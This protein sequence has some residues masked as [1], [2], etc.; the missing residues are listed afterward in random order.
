MYDSVGAHCADAN[1]YNDVIMGAIASKITSFM[2]VYSIVNSDADQRK[3]QSSVSLNFVWGVHR[4]TGEFPA[5][6]ASYAENVSIWWRH[7]DISAA[8]K[9]YIDGWL[10]ERR[11]S[12]ANSVVF[13]LFADC[14]NLWSGLQLIL[15][16]FLYKERR[17]K[18]K[19][20]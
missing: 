17:C 3:Y 4:E 20:I 2:I 15:H 9:L 18:S 11:N 10:Q 16:V 8:R 19:R 12:I 13:C 7:H 14:Y 6:M 5:Q 1:H